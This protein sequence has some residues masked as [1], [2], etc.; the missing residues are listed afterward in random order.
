MPLAPG[1]SMAD[2]T[3]FFVAAHALIEHTG[4]YLVTR[5]SEDNDYM[6]RKWDI[7]GGIVR[8]GETLEQT[9]RREVTEETTLVINVGR[10]IFVYANRDQFPVRQT[11]QAVYRCEYLS[12]DVQL[13]PSEHDL[14]EWLIYDDIAE[15]DTIGFLRELIHGYCPRADS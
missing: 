6:P 2:R 8:A 12:G 13:N 15:L 3:K 11:F 7:P 9:I 10:V 1:V 14:Y 5:R 4:R